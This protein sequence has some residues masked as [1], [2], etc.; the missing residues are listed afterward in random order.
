MHREDNSRYVLYIEPRK[1]EKSATP[2]DDMLTTKV[3]EALYTA[4]TGIA[5]YNSDKPGEE[6]FIEGGCWKGFHV[7]DCGQVSGNREYLLPN[8]LITNSLAVFYVRWYRHSIPDCDIE[9]LLTL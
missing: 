8:G 6:N 3:T 4:K 2:I 9:K 7:T 1:E 5:Y